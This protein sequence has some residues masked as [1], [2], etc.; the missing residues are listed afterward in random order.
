MSKKMIKVQMRKE[1]VRKA[2]KKRN[3]GVNRIR[4]GSDVHIAPDMGYVEDYDSMDWENDWDYEG[5][6]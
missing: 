5:D 2:M 1:N 4:L 3:K 6:A